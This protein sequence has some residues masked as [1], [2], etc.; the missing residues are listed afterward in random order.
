MG[1]YVDPLFRTD[2]STRWPWPEAS[3]LV[4][5]SLPELHEFAAGVGL[6]PRWCQY[7]GSGVWHYDLTARKRAAAVAAGAI[8]LETMQFA[9]KLGELRTVRPRVAVAVQSTF[10]EGRT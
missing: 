6:Q 10:S 5:D 1:V 9:R 3:H 2:P 8:E 4:A 7:G